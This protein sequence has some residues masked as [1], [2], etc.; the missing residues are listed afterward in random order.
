MSSPVVKAR[1]LKTSSSTIGTIHFDSE[2]FRSQFRVKVR[3]SGNLGEVIC[4]KESE[5]E[6]KGSL[7]FKVQYKK[8]F[9]LPK[10]NVYF[11]RQVSI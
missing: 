11:H 5:S 2:E 8:A 1:V 7:Y 6:F 10:S 4:F 3:K 9:Q